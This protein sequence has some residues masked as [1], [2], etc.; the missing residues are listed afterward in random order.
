[1]L[2]ESAQT[3]KVDDMKMTPVR[4]I[5]F[6]AISMVAVAVVVS[7]SRG[8]TAKR[9]DP[10]DVEKTVLARLNE[11]QNA[12]QG[13]DADKVF[14]F[15]LDNENGALAQN[16]RLFLTR[17][18]ALDS[19]KRGFRGLQKVEYEMSQQH[20]SL[21]SPTVALVVG[22]GSSSATTDD[23]RTLASPFV[24]SVVFVLTNGEWK[25]YHAHRSFPP[26]QQ[27]GN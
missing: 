3:Q 18:S 25:V 13:L 11:I 26:R 19:T 27:G 23:G 14:S 1:M 10:S 22:E 15:V 21:L 7:V 12:A 9:P 5:I 8:Q 24:Q 6:A 20:V 2:A 16:G 17:K 4:T